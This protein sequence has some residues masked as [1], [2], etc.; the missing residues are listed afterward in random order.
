MSIKASV[1]IILVELYAGD[2]PGNDFAEHAI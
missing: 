2:L 1:V